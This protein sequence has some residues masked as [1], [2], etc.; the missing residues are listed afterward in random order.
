MLSLFIAKKNYTI[1]FCSR[2]GPRFWN[3][4]PIMIGLRV[5]NFLLFNLFHQVITLVTFTTPYNTLI[6]F[7]FRNARTFGQQLTSAITS[8]TVNS[9]FIDCMFIKRQSITHA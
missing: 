2:K 6:Q 7:F 1:T 4:L 3:K 9:Y 5:E 8:V